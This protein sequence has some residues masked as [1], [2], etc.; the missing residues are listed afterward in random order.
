[1]RQQHSGQPAIVFRLM[2][3]EPKNFGG[4]EAGQN[5][6]AQRA[7]GL[8]ESAEF[9]HDFIA[10]GGGGG[11]APEF[12]R[13][14]DFSVFV[15]WNEPMLLTAY[16]DRLDL[17]RHSFGLP[18]RAPNTAGSGITPRVRVLF[19]CPRRQIRNQIVF[20]RRRR[21]DLAVARVHDENFGRLGAAINAQQK[22]SHA[23]SRSNT[24]SEIA[25][26]RDRANHFG[27]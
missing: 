2:L 6:I 9:A 3:L 7:N 14:Y 22:R 15:E 4:S 11:V 27:H 5:G 17:G 19:L 21:Q 8:L 12:G 25:S 20:L 16:A 10:L 13:A 1:M 18:Q 26:P 23:S 24:S